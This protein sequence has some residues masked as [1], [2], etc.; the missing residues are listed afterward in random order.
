[1][2]KITLS[3]TSILNECI[4]RKAKDAVRMLLQLTC[5]FFSLYRTFQR[6]ALNQRGKIVKGT[7]SFPIRLNFEATPTTSV[8]HVASEVQNQARLQQPQVILNKNLQ[9][10]REVDA[11]AGKFQCWLKYLFIPTI[12]EGVSLDRQDGYT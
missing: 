10:L 12:F 3:A 1:M 2:P 4:T 11:T 8:A 9:V 5:M 6:C 7:E